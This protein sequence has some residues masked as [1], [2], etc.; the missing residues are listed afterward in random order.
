MAEPKIPAITGS[1]PIPHHGFITLPLRLYNHPAMT[2][3][4]LL[5]H[6]SKPQSPANSRKLQSSPFTEPPPLKPPRLLLS[7]HSLPTE[8]TRLRIF[9]ATATDQNAAPPS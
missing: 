9:V 8:L 7:A 2:P 1:L 3:L 5:C 6:N 4:H